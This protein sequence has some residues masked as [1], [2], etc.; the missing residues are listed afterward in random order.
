MEG[1]QRTDWSILAGVRNKVGFARFFVLGV[2][3]HVGGVSFLFLRK[4]KSFYSISSCIIPVFRIVAGALEYF[5]GE[6]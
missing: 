6:F 2:K 1:L 4:A 5:V 3:C